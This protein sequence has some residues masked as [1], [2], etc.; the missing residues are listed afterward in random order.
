MAKMLK[1]SIFFGRVESNVHIKFGSFTV[2]SNDDFCLKLIFSELKDYSL[3]IYFRQFWVDKRLAF[4]LSSD[5]IYELVVGADML[6]KIWLPDTY[7]AND[8]KAYFHRATVLN[9]F[10]R[11]NPEGQVLYSIRYLFFIKN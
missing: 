2:F 11:I 9:K 3:D 4:D 1:N 8:R 6:S 7:I 5:N 10:I